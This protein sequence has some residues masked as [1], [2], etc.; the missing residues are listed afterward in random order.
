MQSSI[1]SHRVIAAVR[2]LI[3]FTVVALASTLASAQDL[4]ELF[5]NGAGG[6]SQVASVQVAQDQ[7]VTAVIN[8]TGNL[9]VIGWYAN[10]NTDQLVRQGTGYAGPASAVAV[11]SPFGLNVGL[12]GMFTTAAINQYG[13]LDIIYWQMQSN[14]AISLIS[15]VH[16]DSASSVSIASVYNQNGYQ[17]F[18]T[19][20]R[21]ASTGNLEVTL[22][23]L[24]STNTIRFKGSAFAGSILDGVSIACMRD[25]N[26]DVVTAIENSANELELIQWYYGRFG[27]AVSRG[28]TT[29]TS[30]PTYH[31]RIA[32]G[33]PYFNNPPSPV[34]A[35]YTSGISLWTSQVPVTAWSQY[36]ASEGTGGN[37]V[38]SVNDL[39]AYYTAAFSVTTSP[40][41]NG[42]YLI[43]AFDQTSNG[44]GVV[45]SANG[46][47]T[48]SAISVSLV[49]TTS[50]NVTPIAVAYPNSS[51]NL[52]IDVWSYIRS[53]SPWCPGVNRGTDSEAATR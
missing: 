53:C 41:V 51:G 24:D 37:V 48:R 39:A 46:A 35:F 40:A 50:P 26:S 47:A 1:C 29:Y 18:V 6:V 27:V 42:P 15:E 20:I 21:N 8:S 11:S 30:T 14:G 4:A 25:S 17:Q 49:D 34:D 22:W 19:A 13:Q 7:F 36:L 9:E 28:N 32:T 33:V 16:G 44:F 52:Q 5:S 2:P 31:N 23:Y 10:F 38:S 45:A 12:T 3:L 43:E